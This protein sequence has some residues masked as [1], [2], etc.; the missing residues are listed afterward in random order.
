MEEALRDP[1]AL[2]VDPDPSS[3]PGCRTRTIGYSVIAVFLVTVITP[4]EESTVRGVNG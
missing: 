3:K 2:E 4:R 1:N